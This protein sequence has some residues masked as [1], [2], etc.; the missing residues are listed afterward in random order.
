MNDSYLI[1]G[2]SLSTD[3]SN[4]PLLR[5]DRLNVE[6]NIT[7]FLPSFLHSSEVSSLTLKNG[8]FTS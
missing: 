5:I 1:S 4:D 6:T 3:H 2:A 8:A 7:G